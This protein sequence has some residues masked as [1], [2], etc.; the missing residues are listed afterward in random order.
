V[1]RVERLPQT[2]AGKPDRAALA[3]FAP[4]LLVLDA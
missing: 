3:A 4:R 2:A 1:C